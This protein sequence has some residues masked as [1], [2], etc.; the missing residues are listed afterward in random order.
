MLWIQSSTE[1]KVDHNCDGMTLSMD[2]VM[3][4]MGIFFHQRQTAW[5][6]LYTHVASPLGRMLLP[7][8]IPN[9]VHLCR[10]VVAPLSRL[11]LQAQMLRGHGDLYKR[12]EKCEYKMG[13]RFPLV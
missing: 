10:L 8:R 1:T 2:V 5:N 4:I 3:I 13:L 7:P 9:P 11:D 6:T 12:L